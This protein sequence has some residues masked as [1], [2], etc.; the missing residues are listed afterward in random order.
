MSLRLAPSDILDMTCAGGA[1]SVSEE[2]SASPEN[3]RRQIHI[4]DT[5]STRRQRRVPT[6]HASR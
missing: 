2:A 1:V 4:V 5:G 6:N 3:T